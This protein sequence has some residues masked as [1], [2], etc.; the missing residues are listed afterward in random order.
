MKVGQSIQHKKPSQDDNL[1]PLINI[2]FL[3]LIFFMVAGHISPSD[4]LKVQPPISSSETHENEQPLVLVVSTDGQIAFDQVILTKQ[5]LAAQITSKFEAAEDKNS[6][7]LL[8]KVDANLAVE[9]LQSIL[10]IIKKTGLKRVA[11]AT[12]KTAETS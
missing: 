3:M 10:Q 4:P 12:Q 8:V 5:E 7:N 1:I 11:L 2:V 9:E 6:F